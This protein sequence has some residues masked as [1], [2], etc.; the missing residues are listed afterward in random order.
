MRYNDFNTHFD[1]YAYIH[2]NVDNRSNHSHKY[3]DIIYAA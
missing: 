1:L 2:G 3:V